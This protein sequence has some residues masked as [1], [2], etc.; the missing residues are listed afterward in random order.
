MILIRMWLSNEN[1][2][3]CCK[4]YIIIEENEDES[5]WRL[6]GTNLNTIGCVPRSNQ[7]ICNYFAFTP[8]TRRIFSGKSARRRRIYSHYAYELAN[9]YI[10]HIMHNIGDTLMP[11]QQNLSFIPYPQKASSAGQYF[12][13]NGSS[14]IKTK[15]MCCTTKEKRD[16]LRAS[17]FKN[18]LITQL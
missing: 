8:G 15:L 9:P 5:V 10:M 3:L 2:R 12:K 13:S 16:Q 11:Q 6:N 4:L 17:V 14:R 1:Q 18:M 7:V